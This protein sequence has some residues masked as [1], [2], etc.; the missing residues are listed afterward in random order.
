[1]L[2]Y[3]ISTAHRYEIFG[4]KTQKYD[5]CY[6]FFLLHTFM[7]HVKIF[8]EHFQYD[9]L[10]MLKGPI[11]PS[12]VNSFCRKL[13]QNESH[14]CRSFEGCGIE[15]TARFFAGFTANSWSAQLLAARKQ[16]NKPN[17]QL[18]AVALT[19]N[20]CLKL[21]QMALPLFWSFSFLKMSWNVRKTL[22]FFKNDLGC[23]L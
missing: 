13:R 12:A 17:N 8:L 11:S 22:V 19:P 6:D 2:V 3:L 16:V 1:M 5:E 15:I 14:Q 7:W 9:S 10:S 4:E 21:R 23:T 20:I 18:L